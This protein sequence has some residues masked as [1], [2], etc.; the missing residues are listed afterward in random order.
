[1]CESLFR[2]RI[3][4]LRLA[5]SLTGAEAALLVECIKAVLTDAIAA[6]GSSL[7]DHV[8]PDGELGYFQHS[9]KV[10]GRAG[11]RCEGCPGAPGCPGITRI[12]QAGRSTFYC[13]ERQV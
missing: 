9:F 6:G 3:S 10:Y 8:R 11:E 4:P 7:K 5:G 1:V 13:A 2:A 12:V